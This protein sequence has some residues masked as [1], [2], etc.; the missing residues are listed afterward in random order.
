[1]KTTQWDNL[2]IFLLTI[3]S[4]SSLLLFILIFSSQ[5]WFIP[6]ANILIFATA[7]TMIFHA[8]QKKRFFY[9]LLY[10]AISAVYNPVFKLQL[11]TATIIIL[12]F[13]VLIFFLKNIFELCYLD[14]IN[15]TSRIAFALNN[16]LRSL[17]KSI[18][19]LTFHETASVIKREYPKEYQMHGTKI[20]W[21]DKDLPDFDFYVMS[22]YYSQGQQKGG[23]SAKG[24]NEFNNI[25][26]HLN[27]N[28]THHVKY[29]VR[30]EGGP[31]K[32]SLFGKQLKYMLIKKYQ[33]VDMAKIIGV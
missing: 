32:T 11:N 4:L 23:L 20:S 3:L 10:V 15:E 27:F 18:S 1:M 25:E 14:K 2:K 7:M 24:K 17:E 21:S 30:E 29:A 33:Y 9:I 19:H 12:H 13:G 16:Y 6:Y 26:V 22:E 8:Y 31:L 28:L 5:T